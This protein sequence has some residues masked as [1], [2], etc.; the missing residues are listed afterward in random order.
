MRGRDTDRS[1]RTFCRDCLRCF[2]TE[3]FFEGNLS[4]LLKVA[5][6]HGM[7]IFWTAKSLLKILLTILHFSMVGMDTNT[8]VLDDLI[9]IQYITKLMFYEILKV[10]LCDQIIYF[11]FYNKMVGCYGSIGPCIQYFE[12]FWVFQSYEVIL[13]FK[14][15][16]NLTYGK[17]STVSKQY[18][19]RY[20]D[21]GK[22]NRQIVYVTFALDFLR[23]FQTTKFFQ[24][25]SYRLE[26]QAQLHGVVTLWTAEGLFE[27]YF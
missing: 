16:T 2:Q 22:E 19:K 26:K 1:L 15:L 8:S 9:C 6:L 14:S 4:Q 10:C 24:G 17:W 23:C 13:K 21:V 11:C 5:L 27:I 7:L 12:L 18:R 3:E 20:T 25:N